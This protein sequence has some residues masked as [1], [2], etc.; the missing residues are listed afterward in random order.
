MIPKRSSTV[1]TRSRG[2]QKV[3][4][5]NTPRT[6]EQLKERKNIK[7]EN[8]ATT[9]FVVKRGKKN[10]YTLTKSPRIEKLCY[11]LDE[12]FIEP[13]LIAQK[14][15]RRCIPWCHDFGAG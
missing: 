2:E 5:L 8:T 3:A 12:N 11:G 7:S 1:S 6:R 13:V 14:A 10:L 4:R 9:M 15:V